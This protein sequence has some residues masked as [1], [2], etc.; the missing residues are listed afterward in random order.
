MGFT[1]VFV[2]N[3]VVRVLGLAWK[4]FLKSNWDLYALISVSGTSITTVL[5]LAG[6]D[7]RTFIQLQKLFLVSVSYPHYNTS[8]KADF[9]QKILMMLIPRNDD[10]DHLFKTAASVDL[11]LL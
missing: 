2:I 8:V 4:N 5:L 6:Y 3:L 7:E 1:S 10:L 9:L 11:S